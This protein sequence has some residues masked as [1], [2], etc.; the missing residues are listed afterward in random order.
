VIE[1]VIT[2][3]IAGTTV[4]QV[5]GGVCAA[6][7]R[8]RFSPARHSIIADDPWGLSTMAFIDIPTLNGGLVHISASSVYRV[9]R[10]IQGSSSA[11]LTRVDFGTE[12]QLTRMPAADVANLLRQA[13]AQLIELTAPDS[14]NIFLSVPAI[15]SVR[16]ADPHQD[17]PGAHAV[18]TV[19][20]HRQAV[21]ETQQ[22][23]QQL[24]ATVS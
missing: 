11:D 4:C 14:T 6:V 19:S 5:R 21:Q 3:K 7:A 15:T 2:S 12:F 1:N 20:G 17:P 9:T 22:Q 24:L 10:G 8:F 18:V 23:V 16:D 13:G